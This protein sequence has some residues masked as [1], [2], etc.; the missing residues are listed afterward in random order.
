[1]VTPEPVKDED[2]SH[3]IARAWRPTLRAIVTAFAS[4]DYRLARP[5][6]NVEPISDELATQ[7]AS[8]IADYGCTLVDLPEEAWDT[9][10]A[11]WMGT[12]WDALIDLWTK[13]EAPSDLVLHVKVEERASQFHF[14]VHLVYVP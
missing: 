6:L 14:T 13:E 1:M 4:G 2:A 9:S 3:P 12:Q 11:Q 10:C 5:I 8:Y 7:I